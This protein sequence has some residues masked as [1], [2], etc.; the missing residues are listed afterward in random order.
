MKDTI[1]NPHDKLFKTVFSDPE[2]TASFLRAYLPESV[3][4]R[5]DWKSLNLLPL[6]FIDETFKESESDL[7]FCAKHKDKHYGLY[8]YILFEHQSTPDK[9]MRFR[10]LK[11]MCRIWDDSFKENPEQE[12]LIPI[13]PVVFYQGDNRWT[14]STAFEDLFFDCNKNDSFIPKFN[15]FLIDQTGSG[16]EEMKGTAKARIA[17]ILM[18]AAF[19]GQ[20]ESL[21]EELTGL[22]SQIPQTGGINYLTVFFVYIITTQGRKTVHD[23]I[24]LMKNKSMGGAML[25][26]AEE[27]KLE[28]KIEGKAEGKVEVIESLLNAGAGW[29]IITKGTGITPEKFAELKSFL[30]TLESSNN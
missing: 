11:Y 6:S 24:D 3:V 23:L 13:L 16:F 12:Q 21:Y 7:L 14:Y 1:E 22:L 25:T 15:H 28:G 26:A 30:K 19:Y 4:E 17:Q 29:D 20:L 10:L 9:W 5:I 18:K 8:L 27:F 2:D